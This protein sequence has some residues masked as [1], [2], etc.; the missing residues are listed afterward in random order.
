MS[1]RPIPMTT[2]ARRMR[3]TIPVMAAVVLETEEFRKR[4]AWIDRPSQ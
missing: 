2:I 4:N 1:H 3:K